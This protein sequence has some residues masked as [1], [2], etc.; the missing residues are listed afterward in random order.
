MPDP[1]Q[2]FAQPA[3][4]WGA[5]Q[6][7]VRARAT[8]AEVWSAI[9]DFGAREGLTYPPGMFQE[10]NRLRSA[11]VGLRVATQRL[12]TAL[13]TDAI[14]GSMVGQTIYTR[15]GASR[16][17]L[18]QYHV[19]VNYEAVRAGQLEQSY[20]TLPYTGSLPGT[21]G[22]LRDDAQIATEA[23]VEGYGASLT[24]IGAIEIGEW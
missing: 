9:R 10:V 5:I 21:V 6:G 3:A 23:L 2:S 16:D 17:L 15:P 14:T 12:G 1:R 24:S 7:S 18:R 8:T 19:R 11:A 4:W 13:N 20:I 22:E